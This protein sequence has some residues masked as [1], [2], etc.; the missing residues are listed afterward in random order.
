MTI[1][2]VIPAYNC[3]RTIRVTLDSVLAQRRPAD[4]ILVLNDGS[5]DET[6]AILKS[7]EPRITILEQENSGVSLARNALC[8][9][10]KGDLVA[11]LDADDFWHP[12]YLETQEKLAERFPQ[13]VAFFVSSEGLFGSANHVWRDAAIDWSRAELIEPGRFLTRCRTSGLFALPSAC[14]MPKRIL[15]RL[16]QEP[17]QGPCAEDFYCFHRLA[18]LGP[19]AYLPVRLMGYRFHE[20]SASADELRMRAWEIR[21]FESL[22]PLYRAE[23]SSALRRSFHSSYASRRRHYAKLLMGNG[24]QREAEEQL[25]SS[26]ANSC[27]PLSWTKSISLLV[28][29]HFPSRL[30]PSWPA[31]SRPTAPDGKRS[32]ASSI[33]L[34]RSMGG[35]LR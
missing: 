13:A 6:A 5:T 4:E 16:G 34:L 26:L 35:K 29:M 30:Q 11:S 20:D 3:A 19:V 24:R 10:A 1:S 28:L 25:K 31:R 14:S 17:F 8:R 32:G 22:D 2:V 9:H 21:G 33:C 12:A 23:A 27:H 7:Y 18:L 15:S